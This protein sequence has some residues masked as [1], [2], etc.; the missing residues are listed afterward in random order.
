MAKGLNYVI[1]VVQP[2]GLLREITKTSSLEPAVQAVNYVVTMLI[3]TIFTN[4]VVVLV[5]WKH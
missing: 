3:V 1:D 5:N 4:K 2:E